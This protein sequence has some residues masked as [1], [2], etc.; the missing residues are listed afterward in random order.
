[1]KIKP[2]KNNV[3][4]K[5]YKQEQKTGVLGIVLPED[6]QTPLFKVQSIGPEVLTVTENDVIMIEWNQMKP[7]QDFFVIKETGVIAVLDDE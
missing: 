1:M 6:Q 3:F 5:P 2:T 7:L 4:V